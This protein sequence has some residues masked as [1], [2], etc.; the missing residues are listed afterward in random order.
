MAS[1]KII[2]SEGRQITPLIWQKTQQTWNGISLTVYNAYGKSFLCPLQLWYQFEQQ[3]TR[4]DVIS[5]KRIFISFMAENLSYT[6]NTWCSHR[7]WCVYGICH[8]H[9][10]LPAI[11]F[12][13]NLRH[14]LILPDFIFL[15]FFF[16]SYRLATI[17]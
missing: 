16:F 11:S 1:C 17:R 3:K 14:F 15:R 10:Q 8:I 6:S 2:P 9:L 13:S 7:H 5:A 12:I 4:A